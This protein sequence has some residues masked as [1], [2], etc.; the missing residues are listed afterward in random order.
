MHILSED[1]VFS[2]VAYSRCLLAVL[3]IPLPYFSG[4]RGLASHSA[5]TSFTRFWQSQNPIN[6]D[7]LLPQLLNDMATSTQVKPF[8]DDVQIDLLWTRWKWFIACALYNGA[9]RQRSCMPGPESLAESTGIA[10][11]T[12][13][14]LIAGCHSI[15]VPMLLL[16]HC[17]LPR[18][19]SSLLSMPSNFLSSLKSCLRVP[20]LTNK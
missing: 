18:R 8:T 7:R 20:T 2:S 14:D 19:R 1:R 15:S 16:D 10:V 13:V 9:E 3:H 12:I 4:L 11:T 6:F 17:G 5:S